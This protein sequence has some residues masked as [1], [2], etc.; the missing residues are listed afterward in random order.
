MYFPSNNSIFPTHWFK[1]LLSVSVLNETKIEEQLTSVKITGK[2][3]SVHIKLL[4]IKDK[5]I[6]KYDDVILVSKEW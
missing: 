6:I 5:K 4:I 2:W 1:I 3:K